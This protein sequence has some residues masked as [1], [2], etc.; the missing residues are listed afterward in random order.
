MFKTSSV[1]TL[2]PHRAQRL[3]IRAIEDMSFQTKKSEK[4]KNLPSLQNR[5][6]TSSDFLTKNSLALSLVRF[7]VMRIRRRRRR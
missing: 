6:P 5:T 1:M 3:L 7:G 4:V 2:A